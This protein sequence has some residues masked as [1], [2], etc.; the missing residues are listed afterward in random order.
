MLM[1]FSTAGPLYYIFNR[2]WP[3]NIYPLDH[4]DVPKTREFMGRTDG[5]FEDE[6]IV[7]IEGHDGTIETEEIVTKV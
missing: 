7:G 6:V 3:V 1:S 2:I 5:Y 4:S